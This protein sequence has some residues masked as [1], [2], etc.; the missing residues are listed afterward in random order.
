MLNGTIAQYSRYEMMVCNRIFIY[1]VCW[2]VDTD[3]M[4]EW[5]FILSCA[6]AF[7]AVCALVLTLLQ[8]RQSNKQKMFDRRIKVWMIVEGLCNLCESSMEYL[9]AKQMEPDL[10][11]DLHFFWMTNNS[12]L[13]EVSDVI[14]VETDREKQ[15]V[16]LS[17]IEL[18]KEISVEASLIYRGKVAHYISQF[19][20]GYE[21]L[22]YVMY[23]YEILLSHMHKDSK[24][25]HWTLEEA[26]KELDEEKLRRKVN[27]AKEALMNTYLK[28]SKEGYLQKAKEKT[29]LTMW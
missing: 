23:Q 29:R 22:L 10:S 15:S 7:A 4:N 6:T 28:L 21:E 1:L 19:L 13:Y 16:L 5:S 9:R 25:F 14:H 24:V 27:E 17:K 20:I 2:W 18:I 11:N 3:L 26:S 8:I 12:F